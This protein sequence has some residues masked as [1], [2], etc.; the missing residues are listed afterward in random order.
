M[1]LHLFYIL[2]VVEW[3]PP[4]KT[5][6]YDVDGYKLPLVFCP[7]IA[8]NAARRSPASR[9]KWPSTTFRRW[10]DAFRYFTLK[11]L[12]YLNQ[13]DAGQKTQNN[14]RLCKE[15]NKTITLYILQVS[16]WSWGEKIPDLKIG[17]VCSDEVHTKYI[18]GERR[19]KN[20]WRNVLKK[21]NADEWD[22]VHSYCF[23]WIIPA[24]SY[25][26]LAAAA[27]NLLYIVKQL[28]LRQEG[29][30]SNNFENDNLPQ[31]ETSEHSITSAWHIQVPHKTT[32]N[33]TGWY[34]CVGGG[35]YFTNK[36]TLCLPWNELAKEW[37]W[38]GSE[39][40]ACKFWR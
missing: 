21:N 36:V 28:S 15:K 40:N 10:M 2:P 18:K 9:A 25:L 39:E 14:N 27:T 38:C 19:Q 8:W 17:K 30:K 26:L 5:K 33:R 3:V 24:I 1:S 37:S 22:R 12:L 29:S 35:L 11:S 4:Q 6:T 7:A 23:Q 13:C 32:G 31:G 34:V 20:T 16:W